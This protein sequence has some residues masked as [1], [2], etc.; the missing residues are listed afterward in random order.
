MHTA[1]AKT[2]GRHTLCQADDALERDVFKRGAAVVVKETMPA[3]VSSTD[4]DSGQSS[5]VDTASCPKHGA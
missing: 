5:A 3:V 2:S 1:A 4:V